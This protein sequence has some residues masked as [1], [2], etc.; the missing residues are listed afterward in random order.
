MHSQPKVGFAFSGSGSRLTFYI[1]FL[2]ELE[3]AK[4]P[5]DYIAACSGGSIVAA[6]YACGR[7]PVLK[8]FL[9]SSK[10]AHLKQYLQKGKN[11]LYS[12]DFV[13]DWSRKTFTNGCR[14]EDVK[15]LMGFVAVDL[16][17]GKQVVMSMGDIARAM[18]ISCTLPGV[19]EP[20][21]W[22]S[23]TLIDGGLLSIIPT[24]VVRQAGMDV[25]IGVNMRGR[26]HM[27]TNGQIAIK[28]AYNF[29]KKALFID[30]VEKAWDSLHL[31][32]EE[33]GE[34][35]E[36]KPGMFSVIGR[37]MDLAIEASKQDYTEALRCD[38]MITPSIQRFTYKN[39]D[40]TNYELYEIGRQTAIEYMPKI[41]QIIA[42]KHKVE[43]VR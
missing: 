8:E 38:L 37:S 26:R 11:A 36:V 1:G 16:E 30:Y 13:E 15:P 39:F 27:F 19:F 9:L 24:D 20:V 7:L 10:I 34:E 29:F 42:D 31:F 28:K 23:K 17:D 33:E 43:A 32:E 21:S 35:A 4:V 41:K 22:G 18:R 14:F 5:V 2:E 6:A 12:L 3:K 25:V 40:T